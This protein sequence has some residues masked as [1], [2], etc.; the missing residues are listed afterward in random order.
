MF[1][2]KIKG[3]GF[4]DKVSDNSNLK[5]LTYKHILQRL[6]IAFTREKSGNTSKTLLNE[7]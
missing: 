6:P 4:S 5:S 7:I 2:I 3:K 1:P